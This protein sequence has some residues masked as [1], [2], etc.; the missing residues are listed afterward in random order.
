MRLM[1]LRVL[2]FNSQGRLSLD[3]LERLIAT[4]NTAALGKRRRA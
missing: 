2:A 3:S 1:P 4:V